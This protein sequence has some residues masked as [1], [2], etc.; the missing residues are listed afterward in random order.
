MTNF[1]NIQRG[2]I[3]FFVISMNRKLY[4]TSRIEN[5]LY[6]DVISFRKRS[7]FKKGVSKLQR[8]V[9]IFKKYLENC[10]N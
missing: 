2:F 10:L 4:G 1:L 5:N 9:E 6:R 8:L 3:F 7:C